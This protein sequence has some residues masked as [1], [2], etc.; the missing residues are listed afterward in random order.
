MALIQI[1]EEDITV[2]TTAIGCTTAEITAGVLQIMITHKAGG[3]THYNLRGSTQAP[4]A[5]GTEGSGTFEKGQ[6][7][8]VVGDTDIHGIRFI[9]QSGEP[10]ATLAIQYFGD[11]R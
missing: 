6:V 8:R 9:L 7:M 10:A 1:G 4:T 11:G 2:S 3:K 5:G